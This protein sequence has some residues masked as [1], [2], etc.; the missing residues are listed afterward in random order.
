MARARTKKGVVYVGVDVSKTSLSVAWKGLDGTVTEFGVENNETGWSELLLRITSGPRIRLA[1]IVL[2]A[3]GPYSAGIMATAAQHT[4]VQVM[5]LPPASAKRFAQLLAR[6]KTDAVDARALCQY[7][8]LMPFKATAMADEVTIRIRKMSRHLGKLIRRRAASLTEQKSARVEGTDDPIRWA[9]EAE[10][11][12]LDAIIDKLEKQILDAL[13]Q[14]PQASAC[15]DNWMAI[16]G[17]KV[18]VTTRVLPELMAYPAGLTGKQ[19]AAMVGLDPRPK[20]SGQ[21]GQRGSWRISKMGSGRIR[22]ILWCAAN[23]AVQWEPAIKTY[24]QALLARGKEKMVAIVAVMRK[25]LVS[26]WRMYQTGEA[27]SPGAFTGRFNA[28]SA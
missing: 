13:K 15:I 2:E 17:V 19:V 7:A 5:R 20:Q 8:E 9:F 16:K 26:L 14:H 27:F 18:G 4:S 11:N 25:L 24:Y 23:T 1:Q 22:Q 3:T 10:Q 21:R 6:A 28:V 12:A